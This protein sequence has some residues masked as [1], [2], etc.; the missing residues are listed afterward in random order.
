[1]PNHTTPRHG[2]R[3]GV[4]T[5]RLDPNMESKKPDPIPARE[6]ENRPIEK[7]AGVRQIL[8][9]AVSTVIQNKPKS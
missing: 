3:I 2:V 8:A 4:S 7:S 5:E 6:P 9:G 1:M